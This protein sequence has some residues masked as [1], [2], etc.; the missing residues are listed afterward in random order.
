MKAK[1]LIGKMAVRE[2][3]IINERFV[4]RGG[5]M[6]GEELVKIPNYD[7]CRL[8]VRIVG[9]T[10]HNI[11]IERKVFDGWKREILDERYCD[12]AWADYEALLNGAPMDD[13]FINRGEKDEGGS[14][15]D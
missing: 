8:A 14:E 7:L 2:Q 6:S 13:E 15:N 4:S 5:F 9:A 1:E 3:P 10:D 11:V 12:D